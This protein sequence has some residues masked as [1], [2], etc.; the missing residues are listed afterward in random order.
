MGAT[1]SSTHSINCYVNAGEK[2]VFRDVPGGVGKEQGLRM[3]SV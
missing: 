2:S 3:G 1:V